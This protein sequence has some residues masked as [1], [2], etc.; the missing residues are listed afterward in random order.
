MTEA[1]IRQALFAM[2]DPKYRDFHARLIPTVETDRIIGVRTPELRRFAKTLAKEPGALAYLDILPHHY[3]EENNLHAFLIETIRDFDTA[4]AYTEKFLP[5]IDNWA[6]CDM[7]SPK[8]FRKHPEE[9]YD[10]VRVWL[11]SEHTYTVR[12]GVVT[13][14]GQFLGEQFRP[15][16]LD[17]AAKA[18]CGEYYIN[19]AVA[20]YF[21]MAL[22]KRQEAALAFLREGRLP[23]WVHN[24]AIQKAVE[25]YQLS[26]EEKAYLR[27]L[28]RGKTAE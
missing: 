4:M 1:E 22:V 6:T 2:Q 15:E 24:K 20:W 10:R 21:S 27:I 11:N 25:S 8:V 28:R 5:Y 7:F 23:A 9:V 13:L 18:C 26:L 16:M 12:Y 3:Y 17:L 19:M 14:M